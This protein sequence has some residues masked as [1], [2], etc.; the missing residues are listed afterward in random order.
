MNQS[1]HGGARKGAGRKPLPEL[2]KKVPITIWVRKKFVNEFL[3]F[4]KLFK[5]Q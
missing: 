3:N 1:K 4:V 5:H 2:E